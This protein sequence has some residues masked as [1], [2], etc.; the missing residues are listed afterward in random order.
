[1][2]SASHP[3]EARLASVLLSLPAGYL[4]R[5]TPT[6]DAV[7]R[8]HLFHSLAAYNPAHLPLF[9][10]SG[11]PPSSSNEPW[12]LREAQ[13][14]Q[15]G[16]EYMPSARGT[17]CGHIFK[18]G[19]STYSCKTCAADETCVLCSRCFEGSEHEGHMVYVS[20]S[21]GNSGCCDCG[22]AEAWKREVRCSIHSATREGGRGKE[23]EHV[24][25]STGNEVPAEVERT[26]RMTIAKCLDFMCDVFSC[27]PEQLRL[28]KTE[29]SVREDE[30]RARLSPAMYGG[31]DVTSGEPEFSVLLWNDEKHTVRDVQYQVAKACR[32]TKTI[33]MQRAYEVNDTGRA[34]VHSST[35]VAD[36]VHMAKVLEQ[37]KI[38]VTVRSA[39]DTFREQMCETIVDWLG[40]IAGCSIG[41]DGQM[42]RNIICEEFLQPWRMGSEASNMDIGQQG[43]DDHEIDE[44]RKL[45]SQYRNFLHGMPAGTGVTRIQVEQDDDDD[46]EDYEDEDDEDEDDDMEIDTMEAEIDDIRRATDAATEAG[47]AAMQA[48]TAGMDVDLSGDDEVTGAGEATMAGYPPPPPPPPGPVTVAPRGQRRGAFRLIMTPTESEEGD[49]EAASIEAEPAETVQAPYGKMPK[50][51][52]QTRKPKPKRVQPTSRHWPVTPSAFQDA[53]PAEPSEDLWQ[54]VRLDWLI[55]YDLRL[56]KTL[57]VKLRHMYITNVATI[58]HFK[59]I[60]GLRFAGLYTPLAEL[61]LV[62][63]REPDHSVINLS[64]QMLTTPSITEEVVERGNFLTNL[65]AILYTFLTTRQVGYPMDVGPRA[66][67]AFDAGSVTNRRMF[68]FFVD[69]RWLFQSEFIQSKMRSE[70]QYLLQ[71]LDLVKLHQGLCPNVRAMG[72]HVEYESDA[73]I[74]AS[75]II[76]EVDRLCKA[77][78]SSFKASTFQATSQLQR[79]IRTVGQM[80]MINS[81]GYERKRFTAHEMRDD[82]AW[83]ETGP[84]DE[85]GQVYSVPKFVIQSEYMSFHHPLHYLLSWLLEHAKS[86]DR[87]E[88]RNLLHFT[89]SDLKDPWTHARTAPAPTTLTSDELLC[90]IFDH[91]LRVCAWLAQMKAGMWVR[92]GITLRHQAH[93]YRSVSHRDIGYQ[94]DLFMIQAGLALCGSEREWP[95]ERFLAQIIDRYQ[96]SKWVKGDYSAIDGIEETQQIDVLEDMY[97]LLIIA[98]SERGNLLGN[99]TDD[100]SDEIIQHDIAHALCFKPLSYSDL[101]TRVTEKIADSEPFQRV[102]ESMTTY[103]APEG[104]SDTGTFELKAEY[105][106]LVDPYF[107]HYS[108]NHREEAEVLARKVVAKKTGKSVE[109]VVFEPRLHDLTG[110]LFEAL[111]AVTRTPLFATTVAAALQYALTP[112]PETTKVPS[113]RVETFLHMILHLIV[114]AAL[115]DERVDRE[116]FVELA[117]SKEHEAAPSQWRTIVALLVSLSEMAEYA[118][119]MPSIRHI[120]QKMQVRRPEGLLAAI[121]PA[122]ASFA[123]LDR[124]DTGSPASFS[125]EDKE[126]RKQEAAARQARVMAKMKEQQNSFLLNQGLAGFD[127]DEFEDI[128]DDMSL[129]SETPNLEEKRKTRS[130]P[131]G[132]CILCQ[133]ETDDQRLYGTFAFMGES[134][135]LRSTPTNDPDFVQEVLDLPPNLDRSA[136]HLRPYG[137]AGKN[138]QLIQKTS[139]TGE[140]QTFERQGLSKG[141]PHA[142]HSTKG[143]VSTTCGHMMHFSCF[144]NFIAATQKRQAQQ[145]ARSHPETIALKE[146]ICPLCKALGNTFLPIVWTERECAAEHELH[147]APV[148]GDWLV[149]AASA[150]APDLVLLDDIAHDTPEY[151]QYAAGSMQRAAAYIKASFSPSL[152]TCLSVTRPAQAS[153]ASSLVDTRSSFRR[154]LSLGSLFRT[155]SRNSA[156][157]T[158]QDTPIPAGDG[159]RQ[160]ELSKAYLRLLETIGVNG[161]GG[162]E[163]LPAG[164]A[165]PVLALSR[166]LGYSISAVEIQHRGT[167]SDPS[168]ASLLKDLSEQTVMHLRILSETTESYAAFHAVWRCTKATESMAR[169]QT[170]MKAQLFGAEPQPDTSHLRASAKSSVLFEEDTF[171]FLADWLAILDPGVAEATSMLQLLYWAEVVKA[172]T[173]YQQVVL[174]PDFPTTQSGVQPSDAFARAVYAISVTGTSASPLRMP[175]HTA[176]LR[177]LRI[178][179]EKYALAFLRKSI[180]LIHVRYGLDFDCPYN[181]DPITSELDRL[182]RLLHIPTL[183]EI[184]TLYTSETTASTALQQ[185]T[186]RWISQADMIRPTTSNPYPIKVP[187]PS[188]FELVGLPKNYD[189]LTELAIRRKCPTTGKEISDPAVCLFCAEIFCSQATCCESPLP[190]SSSS[191]PSLDLPSQSRGGCWQHM[192]KCGGRLGIFINI[193]KCMVLFLHEPMHGSFAHAPYLDRHGEPDPTLRRHHQLF[194]NQRR[195]ERLMRDVW[196]GHGVQ[197][198]VSRRLEAD[199]NPG[200][201]ETL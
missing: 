196:L 77:V 33:G 152:A 188:I 11:P 58:P 194:L 10:P 74:S 12:S 60:L 49:L 26:V 183:E 184:L 138:K 68:H 187:H 88:V 57:R 67:L 132:T 178:L 122:A 64:V 136:E 25:Q 2:V 53:R 135:V 5:Y 79:A 102:L 109:D 42:L 75:L 100:V 98:L 13:G 150:H 48:D 151:H 162:I 198:F 128:E 96:M 115:E 66:V 110:T 195:Y 189:V 118:S 123:L 36:L 166:A 161:L 169:K 52:A 46:D 56:W 76:K 50:T 103:R 190:Q 129:T 104:L 113:T 108:R 159:A 124:N 81:F 147:A 37:I 116:G 176:Q 84:Y 19:E 143:P 18:S 153:Q 142:K 170:V 97:H 182:T 193:R 130:F 3:S 175:Y 121:G 174:Q 29:E 80:T 35:D 40:D 157:L 160:L 28:Q 177:Q 179:V 47:E 93:T 78:A 91:P 21:P 4:N 86:M 148:F 185:L 141:F 95:G 85:S 54:R 63:D 154:S 149:T 125:A 38:T 71:F 17:A 146:F 61:Y 167:N 22:D 1:M 158:E 164:S 32:T 191:N 120:L 173:V 69:M 126:K 90:S 83:H 101:N 145:I 144:E 112:R 6:T 139:S 72:E 197:S 117:M 89:S 7:L 155:T 45:K 30:R 131:T 134:N 199:I 34:V 156:P 39:R 186:H 201:W 62:A 14:A 94:R 9:F 8:Q 137:V 27:A 92:N 172:V 82:M 51:P 106:E 107:A 133:E 15:D 168:A 171:L 165:S 140:T 200:G 65:M 105:A 163:E 114:I 87:D 23:R 127:S 70:P 111:P 44:T 192:Q 119:C 20:V 180:I 59:R 24:G 16:A 55:L 41:S 31:S 43:I 181:V 73:W 99:A